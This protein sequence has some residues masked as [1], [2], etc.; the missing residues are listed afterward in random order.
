MSDSA[1]NLNEKSKN[2][3]NEAIDFSIF[4]QNNGYEN[5]Y[6]YTEN[7]KNIKVAFEVL[8]KPIIDK[9]IKTQKTQPKMNEGHLQRIA[10]LDWDTELSKLSEEIIKDIPENINTSAFKELNNYNMATC[11]LQPAITY[12]KTQFT[13]K[14]LINDFYKNVLMF[15][16][17]QQT[18]SNLKTNCTI[19]GGKSSRRRV[20]RRKTN[21]K[22]TRK[23]K[24][25]TNKKKRKGNKK[26][27]TRART[28]R[29]H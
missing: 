11:D 8:N 18:K 28:R 3:I 26:R 14:T 6:N 25:K 10:T 19:S 21:K 20:R 17:K 1:E 16:L 23:A 29:K 15:I 2:I 24:K 7:E 5:E 9:T 13:I 22:K 4:L 12:L 27:K